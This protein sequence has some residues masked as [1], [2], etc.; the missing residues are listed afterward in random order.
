MRIA[1]I[2]GSSV[3]IVAL[4]GALAVPAIAAPAEKTAI[5][6]WSAAEGKY[7]VVVVKGGLANAGHAKHANDMAWNEGCIVP[8]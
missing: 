7:V 4:V 6:H 3:A 2:L 5:C 1:R 8:G